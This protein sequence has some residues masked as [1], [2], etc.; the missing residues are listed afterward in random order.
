MF[1]MPRNK[2]L[3]STNNKRLHSIIWLPFLCIFWNDCTEATQ[4]HYTMF[5]CI[6]C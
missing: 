4:L 2:T 5:I 6:K 1:V 3:S